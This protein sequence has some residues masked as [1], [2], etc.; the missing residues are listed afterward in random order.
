MGPVAPG[1]RA[2]DNAAMIGRIL[3]TLV[4]ILVLASAAP[5]AARAQGQPPGPSRPPAEVLDEAMQRVLAIF[6]MLLRA[7][8]QY[9]APEVLENGDILIR[10][11]RPGEGE[12]APDAPAD[13]S[14]PPTRI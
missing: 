12:G 1:R 6:E 13:D 3:S 7:V 4:L 14:S 5:T 10:R 8:P 9:A 11:K 2:R